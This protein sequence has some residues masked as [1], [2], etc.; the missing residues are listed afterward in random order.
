M[1]T[2]QIRQAKA[3]IREE[4]KEKRALLSDKIKQNSTRLISMYLLESVSYKY[5]K[6][7]LIY[8]AKK[9]EVDTY[10]IANRALE[11]KKNVYFP[12]SYPKGLMRFF[13]VTDIDA[14]HSGKLGIKEPEETVQNEYILSCE[15]TD[16]CIVP[17]VCFDTY[18]YRIGYGKGYYDRFLAKF[19][20][21]T[22][23]LCFK[24]CIYHDKLPFEKRYDKAVDIV[25]S[26]KGLD[27]IGR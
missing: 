16:L 2:L 14:L 19:R 5:C 22:V 10:I 6:N 25:I 4:Y 13:K 17:A 8:S 27:V 3:V 21:I 12:K 15:S 7:I 23:G 20:G 24:D 26:E 1:T 18:G 11:D 9:N